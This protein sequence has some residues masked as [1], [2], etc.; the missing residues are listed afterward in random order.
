[1]VTFTGGNGNGSICFESQ[2]HPA[3]E[4]TEKKLIVLMKKKKKNQSKFFRI[5]LI[6]LCEPELYKLCGLLITRMNF[7]SNVRVK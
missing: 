6:V 2:R 1:M 7:M 5:L 4:K 3:E